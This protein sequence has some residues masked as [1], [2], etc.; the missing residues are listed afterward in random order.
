MTRERVALITG[1]GKQR[2]GRHVADALAERGYSLAIH[3]RTSRADADDA[4]RDYERRG[5]KA[6]GFQAD[7]TDEPA[8]LKMFNDVLAHFGRIDVLVNTAAIWS[9]NCAVSWVLD[10]GCMVSKTWLP[11]WNWHHQ[12][13]FKSRRPILSIPFGMAGSIRMPRLDL[14]D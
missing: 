1:A 12:R 3:Y 6:A 13:S 9:P 10:T 5:L 7:L 11:K 14:E 4:V 8:V 2:V